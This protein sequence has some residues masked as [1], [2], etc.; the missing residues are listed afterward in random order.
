[1][2]DEKKMVA[3]EVLD[4]MLPHRS[5]EPHGGQESAINAIGN[6]CSTLLIT[7]GNGWGKTALGAN[8]VTNIVC[9]TQSPWFEKFDIFK[10]WPYPK[11]GRIVSS[12]DN[13]SDEG[14]ISL[15]LE[16]WLPERGWTRAKGGKTYYNSYNIPPTGH[17]IKILSTEQDAKEFESDTLGCIWFD[18]PPSYDQYKAC[19]FRLRRGGI[20]FITATPLYAAG[21]MKDNI[22]DKADGRDKVW[23]TCNIEENCSNHGTMGI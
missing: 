20:I 1:M 21:W 23:I 12:P 19:V 14:A 17:K 4:K 3:G 11:L 13:I 5:L 7:S 2:N 15:A 10:N 18:E 16:E 22:A 8:I 9:N 6:G